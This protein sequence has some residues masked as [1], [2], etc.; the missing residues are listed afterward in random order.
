[1]HRWRQADRKVVRA[2]AGS[3]SE[4]APVATTTRKAHTDWTGGLL[5]GSGEVTFDSSGIGSQAVSWAAR[6]EA[7]G[8]KTSPEEL[9]AAAHSSCFSMALSGALAKAGT[10]PTSL[11]TRAEVDFTPGTGITAIRLFL[12]GDVPGL[13]AAGLAAAAKGAKENCPVSQALRAV[14]IELTV[15]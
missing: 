6:S 7:P 15:E 10:P 5:D 9:I 1:M 4:G 2:I 3:T 14:P 11:N 13:D 12:R 8:G